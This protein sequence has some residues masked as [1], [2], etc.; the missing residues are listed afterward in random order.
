M[1]DVF[2]NCELDLE[3]MDIIETKK[4]SIEVHSIIELLEEYKGIEGLKIS[5]GYD[6]DRTP[7]KTEY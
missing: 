1:G 2:T 3:K 5:I 6:K 7:R 4:D